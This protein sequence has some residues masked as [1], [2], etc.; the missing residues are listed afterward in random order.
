MTLYQHDAPLTFRFQLVGNLEGPWA[1]EVEQAWLTATSIINDK[2]LVVDI[3][4]LDGADAR[5]ME[6]LVRFRDAGGRFTL[7]ARPEPLRIARSLGIQTDSLLIRGVG[8]VRAS[9]TEVWSR[10]TR[11]F[12]SILRIRQC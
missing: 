6:L 10:L 12:H 5:G 11:T 1:V 2:E 4:D 8:D 3:S 7:A 9:V